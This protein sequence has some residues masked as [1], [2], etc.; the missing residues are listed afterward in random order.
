ML[1][2]VVL[3][4]FSIIESWN[5]SFDINIRFRY[6]DVAYIPVYSSAFRQ[7]PSSLLYWKRV[8]LHREY[9]YYQAC[10]QFLSKV[11]HW[12]IEVALHTDVLTRAGL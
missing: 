7:L 6:V 9:V 8:Q 4:Q 5:I 1:A 11:V 2:E 10:C 12:T 3:L